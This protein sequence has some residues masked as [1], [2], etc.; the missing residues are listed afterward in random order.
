M[1]VVGGY[2]S[3]NTISLAALCAERCARTTWRT[4]PASI[5]RAE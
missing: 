1:V 2:N 5:R 3:S 4:R